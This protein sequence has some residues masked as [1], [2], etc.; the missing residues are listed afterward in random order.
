MTPFKITALHRFAQSYP[1]YEKRFKIMDNADQMKNPVKVKY[2]KFSSIGNDSQN[3]SISML[4]GISI[5]LGF[6]Y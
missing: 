3:A 4:I 1:I 5:I 2:M 6:M